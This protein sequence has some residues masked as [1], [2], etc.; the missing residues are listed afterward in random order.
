MK[1]ISKKKCTC[2]GDNHTVIIAA[3]NLLSFIRTFIAEYNVTICIGQN[4]E[5]AKKFCTSY[6]NTY[7]AFS[8]KLLSYAK[9]IWVV[10]LIFVLDQLIG[11]SSCIVILYA[12]VTQIE[13]DIKKGLLVWLS[14][15]SRQ[16]CPSILM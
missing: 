8:L 3:Q 10:A 12:D 9:I 2:N 1:S 14:L 4:K 11:A 5:E 7:K 6:Q 13:I 15:S 16:L